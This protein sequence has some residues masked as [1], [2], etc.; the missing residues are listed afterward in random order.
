MY[1]GESLREAA[2]TVIAALTEALTKPALFPWEIEEAKPAFA[3]VVAA[4]AEDPASAL[5]EGA[6]EAAFGS[7]SPLGRALYATPEDVAGL[8]AATLGDFLGA[9]ALGG[10]VV[11]AAT[12]MS[13]ATLVAAAQA[14][15]LGSLARGGDGAARAAA[16]YVGGDVMVRTTKSGVAHAALALRAPAAGAAG[17]HALGVLAA[18][19]G[20]AVPKGALRQ[21][22][23]PHSRVA[24]APGAPSLSA[25]AIPCA[26]VGLIGLAGSA[27]DAELSALLKAA[28]AILKG[29][30]AAASPA[31]LA[32]AKAAYKLSTA[33]ALESRAGAA[34][35][36]AAH[37]D[38]VTS[39][40]QILRA[41]DAVSAA[42]VAS[43]AREAL[44]APPALVSFGSLVG[45]PR[46]DTVASWLK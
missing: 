37:G 43:V 32:R 44:A 35:D 7:T 21:P 38:K 22:F 18:L 12:N 46:Y 2:P 5:I 45:A 28:A 31:E 41:I 10:N 11:I 13:H 33:N 6:F 40:A 15:G 26:D 30:A 14:G 20:G 23:A 1:S 8:S 42:D 19:L 16:T 29:A 25:F 4:R 36:L 39:T 27:P 9:R 24:T 34:A 17:I 3:A